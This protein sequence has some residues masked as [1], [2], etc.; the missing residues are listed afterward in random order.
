MLRL[1]SRVVADRKIPRGV[2]VYIMLSVKKYD[3]LASAENIGEVVLTRLY[4]TRTFRK[5]CSL[6]FTVTTRVQRERRGKVAARSRAPIVTVRV[7]VLERMSIVEAKVNIGVY[8]FIRWKKSSFVRCMIMRGSAIFFGNVVRG[9][10]YG[11]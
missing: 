4:A 7:A 5:C 1:A 10:L 6:S 8:V 3:I 11:A 9:G 2:S